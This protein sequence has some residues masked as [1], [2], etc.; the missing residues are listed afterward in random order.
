MMS[1]EVLVDVTESYIN[2][3]Q[4]GQSVTAKLNAYPDFEMPG[5]VVAVIPTADRQKA[6]VGVRIA[7][8]DIDA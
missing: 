3:V 5:R 8:D 2:R 7:L 4:P 1:L 6:T